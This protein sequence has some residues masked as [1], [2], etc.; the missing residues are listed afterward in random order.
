MG[1]EQAVIQYN[2]YIGDSAIPLD[3]VTDVSLPE[4][5]PIEVEMNPSG[6]AGKMSVPLLGQFEALTCTIN[7]DVASMNA[8]TAALQNSIK[9]TV[10]FPVQVYDQAAGTYSTKSRSYIMRGN[11]AGPNLGTVKKGEAMGNALAFTVNYIKIVENNIDIIE[12]DKFNNIYTV[13]GVDLLADVR[14][15]I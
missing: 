6:V 11:G 4:M 13:N 7:A 10:R 1:S 8:I 3:G 12:L 9:L 15:A 2:V 5:K 14:N